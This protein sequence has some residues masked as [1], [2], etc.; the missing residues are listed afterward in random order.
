MFRYLS[1][2]MTGVL[3]TTVPFSFDLGQSAAHAQSK[4]AVKE[5]AVN[6]GPAVRRVRKEFDQRTAASIEGINLGVYEKLYDELVENRETLKKQAELYSPDRSYP[7]KEREQYAAGRFADINAAQ[8]I[9]DK[10][11]IA[12]RDAHD[13]ESLR[14][15]IESLRQQCENEKADK[16]LERI[17]NLIPEFKKRWQAAKLAGSHSKIDSESAFYEYDRAR[18]FYL[19]AK[20]YPR[21]KCKIKNNSGDSDSGGE[22]IELD[23]IGG[24]PDAEQ[25]ELDP[26]ERV[27]GRLNPMNASECRA[28]APVLGT[29]VNRQYGGSITFRLR[30][31]RTVS[32]YIGNTNERMRYYGYENGM[33]ILHG[34]GLAGS[35]GA[36]WLV[37]ANGGFEFAAKMPGR[38]PGQTFG[39]AAWNRS[40]TIFVDKKNPN[41]IS[42]PGQLKWRL[43]NG[44]A[45]VRQ[46]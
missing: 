8:Q 4:K 25:V 30:S 18:N 15:R 24:E 5:K 12:I 46:Q 43:S 19:I 38:K 1:I 28:W 26:C 29:W 9:T 32:A 27:D 40:G 34:W 22:V 44:T 16:L 41:S 35:N 33:E 7:S 11:I 10:Y 3:L 2:L 39:Q 36:T 37:W 14:S 21:K 20:S 42:L 17:K 6:E 45:W 13:V 31:D 23:D